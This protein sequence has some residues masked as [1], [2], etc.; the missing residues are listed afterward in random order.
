[1]EIFLQDSIMVWIPEKKSCISEEI[2]P[3]HCTVFRPH[4]FRDTAHFVTDSKSLFRVSNNIFGASTFTE[5][6]FQNWHFGTFLPAYYLVIHVWNLVNQGLNFH[7]PSNARASHS[8]LHAH[9][10]LCR[11][12]LCLR[13]EAGGRGRW[14]QR[15]PV[16][17]PSMCWEGGGTDSARPITEARGRLADDSANDSHATTSWHHEGFLSP[18]PPLSA[19]PRRHV[20]CLS[21]MYNAFGTIHLALPYQASDSIFRKVK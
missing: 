8:T 3:R 16:H 9:L 14:D 17:H 10:K 2:L 7:T 18:A 12:V 19:P 15:R 21:T 11:N 13:R 4:V 1:M 6:Q 20:V 5:T